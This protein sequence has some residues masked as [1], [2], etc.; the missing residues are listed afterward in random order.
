MHLATETL[1]RAQR[2]LVEHA[3]SH[4]TDGDGIRRRREALAR[5]QAAWGDEGCPDAPRRDEKPRA[6]VLEC[7]RR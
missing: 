1:L 6:V 5:A 7:I 3:R 2:D 4:P